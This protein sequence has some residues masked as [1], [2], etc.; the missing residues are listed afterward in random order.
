MKTITTIV[1]LFSNLTAIRADLAKMGAQS[2]EFNLDCG[3][4]I[5]T[6]HAVKAA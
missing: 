2:F 5:V 1:E 6:Q 3:K 4:V